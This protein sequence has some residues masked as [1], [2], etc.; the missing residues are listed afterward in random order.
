MSHLWSSHSLWNLSENKWKPASGI[1]YRQHHVRSQQPDSAAAFQLMN[2]VCPLPP[3]PKSRRS[4]SDW[5]TTQGQSWMPRSISRCASAFG[6]RERLFSIR[7]P[8]EV[9]PIPS[10]YLAD[11]FNLRGV[12]GEGLSLSE[13]LNPRPFQ[14]RPA[15]QSPSAWPAS[16]TRIEVPFAFHFPPR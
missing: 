7:P 3:C 12:E 13:D 1:S 5:R 10:A 2:L 9:F 14:F 11:A 8:A 4:A 6:G 15:F 16:R